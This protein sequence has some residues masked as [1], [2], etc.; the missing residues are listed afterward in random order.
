MNITL[1]CNAGLLLEYK[2][3]FLAVDLP[4][5]EFE[6]FYALS[7]EHWN[8]ICER[9]EHLCGFFFTHDHPDHLDKGRLH[10]FIDMHPE[11]PV[12]IPNEHG[13][14]GVLEIGPF[15][16]RY[17]G[18]DHTPIPMA[19]PHVTAIIEAGEKRI[20]ISADAKLDCERHK[21]ILQ[22]Q[23]IDAAFWNSMYLSY[24]D[25]RALMSFA[26][27]VN[28][29][30]HMP[31]KTQTDAYWKKAEK[32]LRRYEEELRSVIIPDAYPT[33]IVI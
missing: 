27:P 23:K 29:I 13:S 10:G 24:A 2:N 5:E 32:N 22:G 28:Y 17:F 33:N 1:L 25:A 18:I 14:D 3:D 6:P 4:N 26:S 7:K 30:Y 20:Y 8:A 31:V 19:P 16:V 11:L 21:E 15:K 12:F 9:K